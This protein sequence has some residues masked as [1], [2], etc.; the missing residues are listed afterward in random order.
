MKKKEVMEDV[1]IDAPL[2]NPEFDCLDRAIF[3][4]RIFNTIKGTPQ[5]S[6]ITIGIYGSWG[7][8]KTTT[9]NFLKYYCKQAG[10]PVASYNPWQFHKREDAWKG[11]VSSIDKGIAV[12]QGKSIGSLKRQSAVKKASETVRELT[13]TTGVG[14]VIGSLVLKPLEGLLEQTKQK[15]QGELEKTLKNKRLFVFIDDLDRAEPEILY[16]HLMLLNEIV[17]LKRCIYIIGLDAAVASQVIKNKIGTIDS[18]EFLDKII[19]WQF[20]LPEPTDFEWHELLDKEVEKLDRNI[21]KDALLSIFSFLPK[22]PRKFKHFLNYLNALHQSFLDRFDDY[23]LN[24]KLLYMAQLLRI[25]FPEVFIKMVNNK[26]ILEDISSG[27]LTDSIAGDSQGK[28]KDDI[29]KWFKNIDDISKDFTENKKLRFHYLYKGLRES[30]GFILAEQ[31]QNHLLVVEV[32]ELFTLK[33][34]NA[35]KDELLS[36]TDHKISEK[37]KDFIKKANKYKQIERVR[38]FFKMLIRDKEAVLSQAADSIDQEKEMKPLLNKVKDIMKICFVLLDLDNIFKGH[39]Q[40]FNVGVFKEW[41]GNIIKWA[42]FRHPKDIYSD[43][44]Q[45]E[46]DLAKKLAHK[47]SAQASQIFETF[48]FDDPFDRKKD[49]ETTHN[50]VK[51]ILER[52]LVEQII[53]RFRRI[54]GIKE[55]YGTNGR[56]FRHE[57]YLL[58]RLN[59]LFHNK[60]V[61]EQL[62]IIAQDTPRNPDIQKNYYEYA[63]MLFY[64]AI[65]H[66][67]WTERDEVITLLKEKE[68]IDI[69]WKAVVSRR[70]NLRAVGSLEE[71]RKKILEIINDQNAFPVPKWWSE[72][73]SEIKERQAHHLAGGGG[74]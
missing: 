55:L 71:K 22:N 42:H 20:A 28:Q 74:R 50:E 29:P 27:M 5:T 53:D 62:S 59:P 60:L 37:L 26:E 39:N 7:S 11:F 44:R 8:G 4:Q 70:M 14:K 1:G 45:L 30:G 41:Y 33:E 6:N 12:W 23:E 21:K 34:Y 38:E 24:W 73:L 17:D 54:D 66:L 10:H 65:D 47:V 9:M 40:L 51:E 58:F 72:M 19:N 49:F 18:K 46:V 13:A 56:T 48:R 43:I 57:K 15:V 35:F 69:V 64:A 67:D 31:L 61:Y 52:A 32:P 3:A 2:D 63:Y 68:F 25:E 16:D 36:L